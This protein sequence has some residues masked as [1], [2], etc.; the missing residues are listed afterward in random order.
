[1]EPLSQLSNMV[2]PNN[3]HEAPKDPEWNEAVFEEMKALEQNTTWELVY[4]PKEKTTI[5]CKW[6][7]TTKYDSDGSF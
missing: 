3:V 6:V 2:I 4:L 7:F 5:G 1:M